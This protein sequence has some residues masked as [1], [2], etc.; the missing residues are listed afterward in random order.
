MPPI[1]HSNINGTTHDERWKVLPISE[2]CYRSIIKILASVFPNDMEDSETDVDR[3]ESVV[4]SGLH[5]PFVMVHQPD[6]G[7]GTVAGFVDNFITTAPNGTKRWEIDLLAVDAKWQGMGI[8][9][10]LIQ[11][12]YD[13]GKAQGADLARA[14][15]RV[16]NIP[17]QQ[18]FLQCR[19]ERRSP[20]LALF[21]CTEP[22]EEPLA[23][24][25][26]A[27]CLIRVET[28]LYRGGWIEK[29]HGSLNLD[30]LASARHY[31][32]NLDFT[33]KFGAEVLGGL[34]PYVQSQ[35]DMQTC[36]Q[37]Y[38]LAG[39]FEWWERRI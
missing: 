34:V 9:K 3:L 38:D 21:I 4:V 20:V 8:G 19:F 28:C 22:G 15:I 10:Q 32:N 11:R 13:E 33:L 35:E 12:S 2:Q 27:T 17:C 39:K 26:H 36:P 7:S 24:P 29:A 18:A 25:E 1:T 31:L 23:D 6:G 37:G 16:D 30:D 5:Y 14:L